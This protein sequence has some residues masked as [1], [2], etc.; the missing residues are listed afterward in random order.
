MRW[1][2]KADGVED[3]AGEASSARAAMGM[4]G[5]HCPLHMVTLDS[6]SGRRCQHDGQPG[7]FDPAAC[8]CRRRS[9]WLGVKSTLV[10]ISSDRSDVAS[11]DR[12]GFVDV[13]YSDRYRLAASTDLGLSRHRQ[14]DGWLGLSD[15]VSSIDGSAVNE[16]DACYYCRNGGDDG[17]AC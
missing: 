9:R 14:Q 6:G 11:N 3:V 16:S 15:G 4:N 10:R 13:C 8:H 2:E 1:A 7:S 17:D 12:D 5:R